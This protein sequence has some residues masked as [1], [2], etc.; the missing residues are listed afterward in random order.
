MFVVFVILFF[1]SLIVRL[2]RGGSHPQ[3]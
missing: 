3:L 2:I 1:L